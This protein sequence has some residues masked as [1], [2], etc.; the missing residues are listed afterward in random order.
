ML[1]YRSLRTLA[2]LV[3]LVTAIAW[4]P[5]T[6]RAAAG[7]ADDI[8]EIHTTAT[9]TAVADTTIS[10]DPDRQ[11]TPAHMEKTLTVFSAAGTPTV[12]HA[13]VDFDLSTIPAGAIVTHAE[14]QL[15]QTAVNAPGVYLVDI[16]RIVQPWE[17]ATTTWLKQPPSVPV[18]SAVVL[19]DTA[20]VTLALD[21][22]KLVQSWLHT[23]FDAPEF[24]LSL[25][26]AAN[27]SPGG[28]TF[29]SAETDRPPRLVVTYT[30]TSSRIAVRSLA[31][32]PKLD[33]LCNDYA[34]ATVVPY[35]EIGGAAY[36]IY[37]R[38]N[39]TDLYVCVEGSAGTL[40][41]RSFSLAIDADLTNNGGGNT[42][43]DADD[44]A[45]NVRVVG[46]TLT[47]E[48]FPSDQWEARAVGSRLAESA[49]FRVS[50]AALDQ[51]QP[52]CG[53]AFGLGVYHEDVRTL[54]DTYGWPPA[55]TPD[56]PDTWV[57]TQLTNPPCPIR[58][59][60]ADAACTISAA[61][62]DV[63][64]LAD[65]RSFGTDSSGYVQNRS[66]IL[67][68]DA[69][70]AMHPI[71][72]TERYRVF[73][74]AAN[75]PVVGFAA[76]NTVETPGVMTLV[77]SEERPLLVHNLDLSSQWVL[78][79]QQR[80]WLEGQVHTA[81]NI[82]YASTDGQIVLGD[83]TVRQNYEGW[84]DADL[85]LYTNNNLRP[86][87]APGGIVAAPLPDPGGSEITY[88][89]GYIHMG[90]A[91]NRYHQPPGQPITVDG[92]PIDPATLVDDWAIVLV[93]EFGHYALYL[94]DAYFGVGLE[95]SVVTVNTCT[96]TIMGWAYEKTN[97]GY[98]NSPD[99][100]AANCSETH[101]HQLLGRNE[102]DVLL[103]HFPWFQR[104][105]AFAPGPDAPPV[106]LTAVTFITPA[107][108]TPLADQTFDLL[109]DDAQTAS[110]KAHAF[111]ERGNYVLS[112]GS[113]VL[114]S[115]EIELAG[116]QVGDRF[117]LYDIDAAPP[118]PHT[119]RHQFGCEF[120]EA[121]DTTLDLRRDDTWSPVVLIDP[122]GPTSIAISV[123]QAADAPLVARVFPEHAGISF[124]VP[125][126]PAGMTHSAVLTL[127]DVTP[128]AF[129]QIYLDEIAAEA[130]P[131]REAMAMYGVDG[132]T[133]PGPGS[134][135]A[136][137]PVYSSDGESVAWPLEAVQVQPGQWVSMQYMVETYPSPG[138]VTRLS[139][140][141][142]VISWP[143]EL[144]ATIN[145]NIRTPLDSV[146][147]AASAFAAVTPNLV[148]R[149]WNG[150]AWQPVETEIVTTEDGAY[151][152]S[153]VIPADR[154]YALFTANTVHFIPYA[155][156]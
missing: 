75:T 106:S 68:G 99:D 153:A 56:R 129:V 96:G 49:E 53:A 85:W 131:R 116:A 83:V 97:W 81:A 86:R 60:V 40:P 23:P 101:A 114:G 8:E 32:A 69:L 149:V 122:V 89:P 140:A 142:R 139:N 78:S 59:C 152:A 154:I 48:N 3:V 30:P 155:A 105:A 52:W 128:A 130:T 135:D 120:V 18:I 2:G 108:G 136:K 41:E 94:F 132:G 113:P 111:L 102:W 110:R 34:G 124:S 82:L 6:A 62:A 29:A 146:V 70:W 90:R 95:G 93:H 121:G 58:V 24:G 12:D 37:L 88:Y 98:V 144:A 31:T 73:A 5:T 63:L 117:C 126:T 138:Q 143:P 92:V 119:P 112:Q 100:W 21:V 50:L 1:L 109:Y 4:L 115:T 71:S 57:Q 39:M 27:G 25:E 66:Q 156:R 44:I 76:F 61:G 15:Y 46:G 64:R 14:L 13:L 65:G 51:V 87:A 148:I 123:T 147:G 55:S 103:E 125:L 35:S 47:T 133:I 107:G 43:R 38:Q 45:L 137:A 151:V 77:V 141:Y 33:G 74:T 80:D 42:A 9:F 26:P 7:D 11:N 150:A 79:A 54:G 134:W 91:W 118:S 20:N 22:T 72:E 17:A 67:N 28:R 104:P 127:P 36:N 10:S 16:H 19:P 84:A 145:V